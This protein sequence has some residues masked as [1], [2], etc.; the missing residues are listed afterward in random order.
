MPWYVV[1][2]YGSEWA[3]FSKEEHSRPPDLVDIRF[4]THWVR[5]VDE[6]G[7]SCLGNRLEHWE[8]LRWEWELDAPHYKHIY[9]RMHY[10][11]VCGTEHRTVVWIL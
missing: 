6:A 9:V 7:N 1:S 4:W 3:C 2:K 8:L 5:T 11:V 10:R